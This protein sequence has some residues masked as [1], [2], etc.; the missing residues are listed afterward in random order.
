MKKKSIVI[1]LT[2][3]LAL[4]ITVAAFAE[5]TTIYSDPSVMVYGP[6]YEYKPVDSAD[7]GAPASAVVTCFLDF[8]HLQY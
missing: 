7:W 1:S 4:I 3:L 8:Q 6:L 2:I 5:T